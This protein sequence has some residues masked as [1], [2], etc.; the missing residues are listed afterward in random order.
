MCVVN[1]IE[2]V[3][4]DPDVLYLRSDR[5][6]PGSLSADRAAGP[7]TRCV[8]ARTSS[9][10]GMEENELN[11]KMAPGVDEGLAATAPELKPESSGPL[12]LSGEEEEEHVIYF[13]LCGT[14]NAMSCVNEECAA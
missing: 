5:Y 13:V 8:R 11:L 1:I 9:I 10:P 12:Y 3:S 4:L 7:A 6:P 2:D 14:R